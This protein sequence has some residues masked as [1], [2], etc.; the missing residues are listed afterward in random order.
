MSKIRENSAAITIDNLYTNRRKQK[1]TSEE[2]YF[3]I[4]HNKRMLQTPI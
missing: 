3:L 1:T 2:L 4:S